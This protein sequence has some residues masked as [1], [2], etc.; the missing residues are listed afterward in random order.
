[1]STL[2]IRLDFCSTPRKVTIDGFIVTQMAASTN[3]CYVVEALGQWKSEQMCSR[4]W[5][6]PIT[7]GPI[8]QCMRL[9]FDAFPA[10]RAHFFDNPNFC[11]TPLPPTYTGRSSLGL[12]G[13]TATITNNIWITNNSAYTNLD[14]SPELRR[15]PILDQFVSD[16]H[17]DPL[18][19]ANYVINNIDFT[20]PIAYGETANAVAN[21][22][23]LG[24]VNRSALGTYLEG[25]GSPM[26]QCALLVYLLRQAG[27]PA[28]LCLADQQQLEVAG[29]NRQP[30]VADQCPRHRVLLRPSGCYQ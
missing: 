16:M 27:Y 1:M 26:E 14:N 18:A 11:G 17:S 24:G 13:M 2:G 23:E 9:A 20:D 29:Y 6:S 19:L 15:S 25:Q 7:A 4:R 3:Y 28:S 21:S 12:S 22:I 10:W 30:V 5:V 8:C